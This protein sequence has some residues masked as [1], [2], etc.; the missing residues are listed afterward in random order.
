MAYE[1]EGKQI[2]QDLNVRFGK[3]LEARLERK[4]P[5]RIVLVFEKQ[6]V[7]LP[8]EFIFKFG[9]SG[10]GPDCFYAFLQASGFT[11][12]KEKVTSA[13]EGDVLRPS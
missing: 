5:S 7:T 6:E 3:L 8:D 11:I 9:Y 1:A 2:A 4:H 12:S 10:S 13:K